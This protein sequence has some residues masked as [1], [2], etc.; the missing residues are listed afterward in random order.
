[1]VEGRTPRT[2]SIR[3]FLE[4]LRDEKNQKWIASADLESIEEMSMDPF[5][6]F[7]TPVIPFDIRITTPARKGRFHAIKRSLGAASTGRRRGGPVTGNL[8]GTDEGALEQLKK[9]GFVQ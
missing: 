4:R 6:R 7:E 9:L 3:E 8:F 1:M 2:E 5:G